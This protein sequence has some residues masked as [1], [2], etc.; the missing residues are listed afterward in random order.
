MLV[1]MHGV[2]W[3]ANLIA[4]RRRTKSLLR[5]CAYHLAD[6]SRKDFGH[7]HVLFIKLGDGGS[8]SRISVSRVDKGTI[9]TSM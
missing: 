4:V 2:K 1:H 9:D 8:A 6:L 7:T 5:V 3:D